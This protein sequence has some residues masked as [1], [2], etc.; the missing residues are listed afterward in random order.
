MM[1]ASHRVTP[2]PPAAPR[3]PG[4]PTRAGRDARRAGARLADFHRGPGVVVLPIL[5]TVMLAFQRIRLIKIRRV[6]ASGSTRWA[7]SSWS[8]SPGLLAALRTT[9]VY[10]VFGTVGSIVFGLVAALRVR[11]PFR[12]RGLVRALM[13]LPYV[14][15]VV[16]VTF[17]WQIMLNPQFGIVNTWGTTFFG[18][19][20]PDRLPAS[21]HGSCSAGIGCR[22]RC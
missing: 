17:V 5:W 13:L 22:R 20:S 18:W 14:A 19:D 21:E 3:R 9:L 11:R 6:D 12:G 15:P 16:A 7:T 1:P 10:T 8:F 4:P 2:L